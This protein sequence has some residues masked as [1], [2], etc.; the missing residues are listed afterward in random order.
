MLTN[1]A[2]RRQQATDIPGRTCVAAD[3]YV[4]VCSAHPPL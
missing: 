4:T 1:I 2:D 3:P